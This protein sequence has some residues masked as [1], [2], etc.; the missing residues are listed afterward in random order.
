VFQVFFFCLMKIE[1]VGDGDEEP[2]R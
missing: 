1:E 2:K